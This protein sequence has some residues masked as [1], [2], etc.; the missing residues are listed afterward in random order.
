MRT[1]LALPSPSLGV[2][3]DLGDR[4]VPVDGRRRLRRRPAPG[5][6]G[7]NAQLKN[8]AVSNSKIK[9]NSVNYKKIASHT[10]G[11]QRVDNTKIQTRVSGTCCRQLGDQH[12]STRAARSHATPRCRRSSGPPTDTAAVPGTPTTV[13][14]SSLPGRHLPAGVQRV[15]QRHQRRRR[16]AVTVT[17]TLQVGQRPADQCGRSVE[18]GP[19]C[20]G[21]S[22]VRCR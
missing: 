19:K 5:Q 14:Q 18:I 6:H 22:G 7:R 9:D 12:R 10:I 11:L 3:G 8:N 15:R 16:T 17:C 2:D 21:H 20:V 13:V 4:T 1:A